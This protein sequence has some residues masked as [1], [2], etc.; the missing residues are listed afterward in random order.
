M[1]LLNISPYFEEHRD[2]Y[3]D[4]LREVRATGDFEPWIAFFADAV[5]VQ[6]ERALEKA[7]RLIS[8]REEIVEELHR[9]GVRGLGIRIA[10]D[11]IDTPVL[12][13]TRTAEKYDVSFQ[14]ANNAIRRLA[15]RGVLNEVTGRP[16]ARLFTAP[17]V[18]AVIA[19]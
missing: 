18:I 10:E 8:I 2:A 4:G 17:R 12:T 5:Q 11:L 19:A 1:P 6:S 14:A 9:H 3:V 7:D 15:E 16:Y 13:P